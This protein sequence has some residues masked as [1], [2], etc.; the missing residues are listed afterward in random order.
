MWNTVSWCCQ[1]QPIFIKYYCL[2]NS[3]IQVTPRAVTPSYN[4]QHGLPYCSGKPPILC[5]SLQLQAGNFLM[6]ILK[7]YH[8]FHW[9]DF[10]ERDVI[11]YHGI[12][13]IHPNVNDPVPI[14]TIHKVW[15]IRSKPKHLISEQNIQSR[16]TNWYPM[17]TTELIK[18]L[19]ICSF[20]PLHTISYDKCIHL[21]HT[22]NKRI[23]DNIQVLE[24]YPI[25]QH[26]NITLKYHFV[27]ACLDHQK[28]NGKP[29][30]YAYGE[31]KIAEA[32]M[33]MQELSFSRYWVFFTFK[34][35]HHRK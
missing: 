29:W 13:W 14:L 4:Q 6:Y 32:Y 11:P 3:S 15:H 22:S 5:H 31:D 8:W 23:E 25:G 20:L 7:T 28:L 18:I 19:C 26:Q 10:P 30:G 27:K 21:P 1:C 16:W 34:Y 33:Y 9:W 24:E 12:S 17:V 2:C 35:P